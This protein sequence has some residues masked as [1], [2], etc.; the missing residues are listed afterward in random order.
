MKKIILIISAILF[1]INLNAQIN[2]SNNTVNEDSLSSAIGTLNESIGY[3]SFASGM[4]CSA[5]GNYSTALGKNSVASGNSSFAVGKNSE[6]NGMSSVAM[7]LGCTSS[8]NMG[9]SLGFFASANNS[10]TLAAGRN[11]QATATGSFVIGT[12]YSTDTLTN[13][14]SSSLMIGINSTRPTFFVGNSV[15]GPTRTGNIG[16]GDVT[17]PEAKLHIKADA[18]ENATLFLQSSDWNSK[19]AEIQIGTTENTIKAQKDIGLSFNTEQNFIFNNGNI[20]IDDQNSGFVLKS[21][22]GQCWKVTIDNS[23]EFIKEAVDCDIFTT[24]NEKNIPNE[25]NVNIFPNPFRSTISLETNIE[26]PQWVVEI[27]NMNGILLLTKKMNSLKTRLKLK[28]F[29]GTEY[30]I[31]VSDSKGNLIRSEKIMK[32]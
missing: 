7:G 22:D 19:Y 18:V 13:N 30:L 3:T 8:G 20:V 27:Y 4:E 23:G 6:A 14:V 25:Y 15:G 17:D 21:P 32:F 26:N 24:I 2:Y 16:I 11:V 29:T 10:Y 1:T 28:E 9:V 5:L 31:R 12:G